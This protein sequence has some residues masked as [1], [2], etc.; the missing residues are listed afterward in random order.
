MSSRRLARPVP[1]RFLFLSVPDVLPRVPPESEDSW[2]LDR[3]PVPGGFQSCLRTVREVQ[4]ERDDLL[5]AVRALGVDLAFQ[6]GVADELR[7]EVRQC[8]VML[9][10]LRS[11]AS[12]ARR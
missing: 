6:R 11:R 9:D 3:A 12:A 5:R 2:V 4:A 7:V 1:G 8:R 10:R